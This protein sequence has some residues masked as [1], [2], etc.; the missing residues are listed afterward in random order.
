[1]LEVEELIDRFYEVIKV[2]YPEISRNEVEIICRT[3]FVFLKKQMAKLTLPDIRFTYWGIFKVKKGRRD[4]IP[5]M[6][7]T[8]LR[9]GKREKMQQMII[10]N[11]N[12]NDEQNQTKST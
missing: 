2:K 4:F 9:P 11:S 7:K 1:M 10:L 3:P 12:K 5:E 8:N 6:M